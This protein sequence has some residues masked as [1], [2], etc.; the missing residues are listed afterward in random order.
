TVLSY[1]CPHCFYLVK[2]YLTNDEAVVEQ[3]TG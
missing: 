2:V 3:V 1:Q